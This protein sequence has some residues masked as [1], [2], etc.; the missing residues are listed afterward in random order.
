MGQ[1]YIVQP[2][3][4]AFP[5]PIDAISVYLCF[6]ALLRCHLLDGTFQL[7]LKHVHAGSA[8]K[9]KMTYSAFNTCV[10][11]VLAPNSQEFGEIFQT[12]HFPSVLVYGSHLFRGVKCAIR[13]S[14]C[15]ALCSVQKNGNKTLQMVKMFK[16]PN[17]NV[18]P[19]KWMITVITC[20]VAFLSENTVCTHPLQRINLNMALVLEICIICVHL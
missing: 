7:S 2:T 12:S 10:Y 8:H 20:F 11:K 16:A 6:S 15:R 4:N 5:L 19:M 1:H 3:P 17:T 18:L 9:A 13:P 14:I